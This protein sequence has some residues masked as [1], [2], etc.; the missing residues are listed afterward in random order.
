MRKKA[1]VAIW[2]V[3][4]ALAA[5]TQILGWLEI[6]PTSVRTTI[7]AINDITLSLPLAIVAVLLAL[8]AGYLAGGPRKHAGA[9]SIL[10]A[11]Y[12]CGERWRDVTRRV[13]RWVTKGRLPMDVTNDNLGGDPCPHQRKQL[14]V[15]YTTKHNKIVEERRQ[16]DLP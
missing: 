12:G 7:D 11:A 8:G 16:L 9:L 6:P 4:G 15:D 13:Q 10:R 3:L 1:L 14:R 5:V 2:S